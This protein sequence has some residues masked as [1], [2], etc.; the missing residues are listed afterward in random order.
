MA[1]KKKETQ[2]NHHLEIITEMEV[3]I[4][5]PN[6]LEAL[7]DMLGEVDN[8]HSA[9]KFI[10]GDNSHRGAHIIVQWAFLLTD[11]ASI[12]T[13]NDYVEEA[14]SLFYIVELKDPAEV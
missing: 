1:G 5:E 2:V 4:E 12:R 11:V 6:D 13:L 8:P 10:T 9:P 14:E 3:I 7:H